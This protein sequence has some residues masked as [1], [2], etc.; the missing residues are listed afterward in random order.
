MTFTYSPGGGSKDDIRFDIGDTDEAAP[1]PL[2]LEDEEIQRVLQRFPGRPRVMCIQALIAKFARQPEGSVG[3][4][5]I[6]PSNRAN[7]L[8][9]LLADWMRIEGATAVPSAG[10]ISVS[11]QEAAAADTDRVPP[12]FTVGMQDNPQAPT[13]E[14]P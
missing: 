13:N 1:P 8:R 2:R 4:N 11:D 12:S 14:H 10:G 3:P 6:R 9:K 5:V 7:E